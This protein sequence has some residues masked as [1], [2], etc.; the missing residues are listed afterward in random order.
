MIRSL[1]DLEDY[2]I[3]ATDGSVGH[4]KDFL[5]D[6]EDWVIR[7]FVVKTGGWLSQRNVLIAPNAIRQPNWAEK[8]LLVSVTKEQVKN[9]PDID[10]DKP[11]SRQHEV[12]YLGYYGY[13]Y[14]WGGGMFPYAK[15]PPYDGSAPERRGMQ[16]ENDAYG[17][18]ERDRHKDDDPHLRS[19]K[20]IIGYKI[21]ATDGEVGHVSGLLVDEQNWAVRYLVI[22]TGKWWAGQ[23]VLIAPEWI[24][25]V[26]WADKAVSIDL[27]R[28]SVK[29]APPY[30]STE[31]LNRQLEIGLYQHYE[32][33]GYWSDV[34]SR[35]P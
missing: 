4:V 23:K 5:F 24:D 7:Y 8:L 3:G 9:S 19:C 35:T 1:N 17:K 18:S 13:P 30:D 16:Q 14:Y 6:D 34:R 31:Q 10:T 20:A 2:A 21:H 32:R 15:F 12:E 33:S 26:S 28:R 11:V 25:Q 22:D 27:T 29:D